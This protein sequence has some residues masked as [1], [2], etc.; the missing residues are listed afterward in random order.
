MVLDPLQFDA[1]EQL[2]LHENEPMSAEHEELEVNRFSKMKYDPK[3]EDHSTFVDSQ[4][5]VHG[6]SYM[7]PY[8]NQMSKCHSLKARLIIWNLIHLLIKNSSFNTDRVQIP[9]AGDVFFVVEWRRC[10]D[11]PTALYS[12]LTR[13]HPDSIFYAPNLVELNTHQME[14]DTDDIDELPLPKY[15]INYVSVKDLI[16]IIQLVPF[17]NMVPPFLVTSVW[18]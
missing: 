16:E 17:T 7:L 2:A 15:S 5:Q 3:N 14:D 9:N 11:H 10:A 18:K 6:L 8:L 1:E 13:S 4:L 12:N